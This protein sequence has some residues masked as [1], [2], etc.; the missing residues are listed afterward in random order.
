MTTGVLPPRRL[1]W[2]AQAALALGCLGLDPGWLLGAFSL[3]LVLMAG[4]KLLEAR[5]RAGRRLVALLQLVSCGLLA[6]QQT[7]LLPSLLQLLATLL[8]LAG[9]LQLEGNLALA[10]PQ[11]LRRSLRV[12]AAALPMALVL[13][14]L[15][16]RIGPFGPAVGGPGAR[17]STGLSDSLDPGSIATLVDNTSPAARV[18]FSDNQPPPATER[19][20]RVLVHSQFD[21]HRW[22]REPEAET[23]PAGP[24][25]PPAP[26][27]LRDQVW[28]VEP[29]RFS[30]VPWNGAS[31][32]L[33]VQLR[34]LPTGEL[35]LLRP[36]VERRSYRLLEQAEPLAW[37]Q[38][39]PRSSDLQVPP[40]RNPRLL[41]LGR[42]WGTLADPAARVQAAK[43]WFQSQGFR[44]DTQPGSLPE[45]DGLDIFLFE[46]RLGFCGHYASAFSALMRAAGVPSR[47]VSGYL[48]GRWVVPLGGASY[49][50]L[51]QSDAHAWSEVWLPGQG[52]QRL[53]PSSWVQAT[54]AVG[55]G[56]QSPAQAGPGSWLQRQWW[57]LDMAWSR[58]WLGF[59]QSRQEA[60]LNWLLGERR[61]ALGWLILAGLAAGLATGLVLLQRRGERHGD[62]LARDLADLLHLL[63]RLGLA[64]KP[65]E[66]LE[67]LAARAAARHP[68]LAQPLA[69]L[70][71][72][73]GERRFGPQTNRT[74]ARRARQRWRAS[75]RQ[76]KQRRR[77]AIRQTIG[78]RP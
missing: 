72:C 5:D 57:G 54:G 30:A 68:Q 14:L 73:H 70:V 61:W 32:P 63:R 34:P 58:W 28:L 52:W 49:L 19:Y 65:G 67:Q 40:E 77:D 12:L 35:R 62:H 1:Q 4:L 50:E 26:G 47:V 45:P 75:L 69:E 15:V 33:D 21:G 71:A 41:A 60:L 66:T 2:L 24:A 39:P 22:L 78:P 17:A 38:Q 74:G 64:A 23:G 11:L 18:A 55:A 9:L 8:S 29:S 51:R 13:F 20:W 53:D 48:G 43:D 56:S 59:D 76:L 31:R 3:A 36:G 6:A 27:A 25:L 37:Q 44:Y 46:R 7:D 16:P 10:W 42:Q